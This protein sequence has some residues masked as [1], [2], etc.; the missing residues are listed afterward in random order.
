MWTGRDQKIFLRNKELHLP[1]NTMYPPKAL[2]MLREKGG[3]QA[4]SSPQQFTS[5]PG[6]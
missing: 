2:P 4:T 1:E 5:L 6:S 3:R